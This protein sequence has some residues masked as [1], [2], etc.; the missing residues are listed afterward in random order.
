MVSARPV[1]MLRFAVRVNASSIT[2]AHYHVPDDITPSDE[3]IAL[4]T[5]IVKDALALGIDVEDHL[6]ITDTQF[7][8]IRSY[9]H[10]HMGNSLPE[11][12][13]KKLARE[14]LSSL[15]DSATQKALEHPI[16]SKPD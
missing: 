13:L 16:N 15:R 11:Q 14:F 6:I 4:T 2:L 12:E 3:D 7:G 1:E 8:S 5:V 10:E 9:M